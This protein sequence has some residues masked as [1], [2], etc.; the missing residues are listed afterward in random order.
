M[1]QLTDSFKVAALELLEAMPNKKLRLA[2]QGGGCSGFQYSFTFDDSL[3]DD[4]LVDGCVV[5]D[6]ISSTYLEGVTLDYETGLLGSKFKVLNPTA[7]ATC[8]CGKSFSV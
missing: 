6:P 5:V 4:L 1:I 7:T 2:V 3:E 8:G